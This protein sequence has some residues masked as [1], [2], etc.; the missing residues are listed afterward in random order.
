MSDNIIEILRNKKA[1][2]EYEIPPYYLS[3]FR[4]NAKAEIMPRDI[5]TDVDNIGNTNL[6]NSN[7]FYY[8][9]SNQIILFS[10]GYDF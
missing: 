4:Y 2:F 6:N 10:V 1:R 5:K 3:D 7:D 8:K 9:Y